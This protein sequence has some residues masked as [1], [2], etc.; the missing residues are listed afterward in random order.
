MHKMNSVIHLR[1]ELPA[2]LKERRMTWK[3]RESLCLSLANK[4]SWMTADVFR[5]CVLK[6]HGADYCYNGKERPEYRLLHNRE[7]FR[8]QLVTLW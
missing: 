5:L 4:T 2:T 3:R 8:Q 7:L 1:C 6:Q